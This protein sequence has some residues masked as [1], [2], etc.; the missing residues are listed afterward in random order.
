[1]SPKA[2]PIED[3][4]WSST[5]IPENV[6]KKQ[7]VECSH[8]CTGAFKCK[9]F[10]VF[11]FF[12]PLNSIPAVYVILSQ[13]APS[14][15]AAKG[16]PSLLILALNELISKLV[17]GGRWLCEFSFMPSLGN[18]HTAGTLT[19]PSL[20]SSLPWPLLACERAGRFQLPEGSQNEVNTK[21]ELLFFDIMVL[22]ELSHKLFFSPLFLQ[23]NPGLYMC[24]CFWQ[25]VSQKALGEPMRL[26]I[27]TVVS[28]CAMWSCHRETGK[29]ITWFNS[30]IRISHNH[31]YAI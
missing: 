8:Y 20:I 1:M 6:L 19:L 18:S 29:H 17:Q 4:Y 24:I 2:K 30:W 5:S 12:H 15:Q 11:L 21:W 25:A 16:G 22:T 10:K 31:D 26:S 7:L 9:W 13:A 14:A 27:S 3:R 23:E 28:R